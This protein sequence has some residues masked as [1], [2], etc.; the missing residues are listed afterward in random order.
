M[1]RN[2]RLPPRLHDGEKQLVPILE[3]AV[4]RAARDPRAGGHLFKRRLVP[5]LLADDLRRGLD[6]AGPGPVS[7]VAF[8]ARFLS[9]NMLLRILYSTVYYTHAHHHSSRR[10]RGLAGAPVC[11][12]HQPRAREGVATRLA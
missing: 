12:H 6:E 10:Y 1:R 9:H 3:V 8:P 11:V 4:D 5:A 7:L 2:H